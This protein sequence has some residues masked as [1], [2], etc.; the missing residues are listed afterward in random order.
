M[1]KPRIAELSNLGNKV[2]KELSKLWV[3]FGEDLSDRKA[4]PHVFFGYIATFSDLL[5]VHVS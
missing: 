1:A 2:A 3:H 4:T 5:V